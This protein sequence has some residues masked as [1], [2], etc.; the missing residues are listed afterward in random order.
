M[1]KA[2]NKFLDQK[3]EA[4]LVIHADEGE[5]NQCAFCQE[6]LHFENF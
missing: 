6:E 5:T 4:K 2:A 3:P 1:K